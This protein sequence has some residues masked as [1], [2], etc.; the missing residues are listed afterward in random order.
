MGR[1]ELF[2]LLL[3]GNASMVSATLELDVEKCSLCGVCVDDCSTGAISANGHDPVQIVFRQDLCNA[4]GRCSKVCPEEC[5]MLERTFGVNGKS[6]VPVVLT[7]GAV[8]RCVGCGCVVASQAMIER[9]RS[10]LEATGQQPLPPLCPR[11]KPAWKPMG[12]WS[13][14]RFD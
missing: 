12:R 8:A 2:L 1:R 3:Q 5:L 11:C 4:C 10:T 6:V 7:D 14:G 13:D 9:V